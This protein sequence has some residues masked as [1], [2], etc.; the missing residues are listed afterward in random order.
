[1]LKEKLLTLGSVIGI[2]A[3]GACF[4][5][6]YKASPP[7]PL[8]IDLHG[9]RI[10]EVVVA[11]ESEARHLDGPEIARQI[12]YQVN[13]RSRNTRVRARLHSDDANPDGVLHVSILEESATAAEP[14]APLGLQKWVME[15]RVNAALTSRDGRD[16]WHEVHQRYTTSTYLSA[17]SEADAWTKFSAESGTYHL[18]Y[19]LV[20]EMFYGSG[21]NR[22]LAP[23]GG[24]K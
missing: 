11:D 20:H 23:A 18:S 21:Q 12:V 14:A 4:G 8:Q 17:E 3:C 16:I 6:G 1:M 22:G 9:I 5:P 2:L 7:P 19:D 15:T 24:A 10:I 13:T